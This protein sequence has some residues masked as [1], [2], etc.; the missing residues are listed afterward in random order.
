MTDIV[1][2]Q[3]QPS[4]QHFIEYKV[5]KLLVQQEQTATTSNFVSQIHTVQ[6]HCLRQSALLNQAFQIRYTKLYSSECT[7]PI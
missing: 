1:E 6:E 2:K 7:F 4:K 5:E 3:L